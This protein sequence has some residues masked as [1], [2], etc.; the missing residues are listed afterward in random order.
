M[1]E[2]EPLVSELTLHERAAWIVDETTR[3]AAIYNRE[4]IPLTRRTRD[5]YLFVE[6]TRYIRQAAVIALT[7]LSFFELPSYCSPHR[8][9]LSPDG[10]S[11]FLSGV[12]YLSPLSQAV[13]NLSLLSILIFFFAYDALYLP[14]AS[15]HVFPRGLQVLFGVLIIDVLYVAQFAG[16][17][18][19]RF[20]PFLRVL[21]PLFYFHSLRECTFA[22]Y[23]V[24]NPFFDIVFIVAIFTLVF[25]WIVTLVF[26]E[27]PEADRY[28]GNLITGLYSAFTSLTTADWPM[29]I[30][31][32]LDVS[33]PS[34]L[35]F[36]AFIL[37]GVLMLLNVL[38]AVVYN[39][40]TGHMEELVIAKLRD[41][42]NSLSLAYDVL[43]EDDGIASLP[44]VKLLFDELRKN[45]KHSHIDDE[46]A[47]FLFTALDSDQDDTINR[48]EF[49]GI[50]DALQLKFVLE[51][52]NIS[53]VERFF[54]TLYETEFWQRLSKYVRSNAFVYVM[55]VVMITN[56]AVVVFESTM[57]LREQDTPQSVLF[58]AGVEI[59]FS[60]LYILEMLLKTMSQGFDRYWRD[61][62][63]RFDFTVTWLLLGG[64]IYTLLPYT[65][66]DRT[67]VRYLVL[68]RC[69]RLFVLLAKLPR[70]RKLVQVF[71]ILIPA[72]AP[73]FSVFF[74]SLYVF[75]A[76]GVE[77]FG[78]LIYASNP[79]LDPVNS[80]LVDAYVGNDYWALNFNDMA[81]GW[82]MLFSSVIV[83]Y[84]TE[85]AEAIAA[86]S[87]FGQWTKWFFIIHFIINTLIVSNCVLAFVVDLFVMEDEDDDNELVVTDLQSRYGT[88][89]VKVHHNYSTAEYVYRT[90]FRDRVQQVLAASD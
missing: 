68:L 29:Q 13:I 77:L 15:L 31:A 23:A 72:S 70:F 63:N 7:L 53:P 24:L 86:T 76:A 2:T 54:P 84:M 56:V 62:G 69:L 32:V 51:L 74:L 78:G 1:S 73:L 16:Y 27:V 47:Q 11:L 40:Y 67:I 66:N 57:D 60:F 35:L 34:A 43:I 88:K 33:R 44:D 87:R 82:Q 58:F 3:G 55:D 8:Q 59:A 42:R 39:A 4:A 90:M 61:Y 50:V 65:E 37:I 79:A 18:P 9:C 21:L 83:A 6:N 41:R 75:A 36:L 52:E 17:P 30:M 25:G 81:A 28:F 89:R 49:L 19:I 22:I 26:H 85:I 38:L 71:T 20:A 45:K 48:E 46:Q 12:P 64:A 14:H 10:S 5:R 80:R